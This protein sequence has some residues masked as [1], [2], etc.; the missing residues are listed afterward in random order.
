MP[1]GDLA[2]NIYHR[3]VLYF[4]SLVILVFDIRLR[5]KMTPCNS[6]RRYSLVNSLGKYIYIYSILSRKTF[7]GTWGFY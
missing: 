3:A 7:P 1:E 4:V 5:W 6:N 2:Q